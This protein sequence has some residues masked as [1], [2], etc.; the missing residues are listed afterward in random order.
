MFN[1]VAQ[2]LLL[3]RIKQWIRGVVLKDD[4]VGKMPIEASAIQGINAVKLASS[5]A[6]EVA[7]ANKEIMKVHSQGQFHD[8]VFMYLNH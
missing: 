1:V 8:F 3:R 5:A 4:S 6:E 2:R 7:R